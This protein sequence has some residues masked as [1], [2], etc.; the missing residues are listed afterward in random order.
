LFIIFVVCPL[1][2]VKT[3]DLSVSIMVVR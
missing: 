2:A 1:Q 3:Q